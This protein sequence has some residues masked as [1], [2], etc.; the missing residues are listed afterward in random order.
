MNLLAIRLGS[1]AHEGGLAALVNHVGDVGNFAADD[2]AERGAYSA[3]KSHG[4]DAVADH[5]AARSQAL[6]PH[7]VD[8]VAGQT[9][10][11]AV[12][13]HAGSANRHEY[14]WT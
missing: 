7:A 5:D 14:S 6:E 11:S 10:E 2:A 3:E 12:S 13:S 8:L 1:H 4:L 9:G